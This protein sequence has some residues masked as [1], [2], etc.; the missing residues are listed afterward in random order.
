MRRSTALL[1]ALAITTALSLVGV[2]ALALAALPP[3]SLVAKPSELPG[4][5]GAKVTLRSGD[6]PSAWAR[7]VLQDKPAQARKDIAKLKRAGFRQGAEELLSDS[8]G[9]AL[10]LTV[11]FHTTKQAKRELKVSIPESLAGQGKAEIKRF[12]IA[13]IPGAYAYTAVEPGKPGAAGNVLFAVGRCFVVVGDASRTGTGEQAA[14]VPMDG[15]PA[16]YTQIKHRCR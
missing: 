7:R 1:A 9:E 3:R 16:L 13:S 12:S 14:A 6:T 4:F 10:S 5:A 15:G 8:Q 2:A 11:V